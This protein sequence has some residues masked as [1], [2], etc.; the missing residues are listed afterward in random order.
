MGGVTRAPHDPGRGSG[1]RTSKGQH[2]NSG[3][4]TEGIGGDDTVL[5]R[6]GSPRADGQGAEQLKDQGADHGHAVAD[7]AAGDTGGPCV[8]DI[9]GTVVEGIEESE[10]GAAG[11]DGLGQSLA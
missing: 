7:A 4:A 8:G 11:G 10:E 5:Y 2:L 1:E 6:V 9:V 3:V